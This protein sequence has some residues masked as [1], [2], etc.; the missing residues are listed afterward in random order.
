MTRRTLYTLSLLYLSLPV[1]IFM[2]GWL[3]WP[4]GIPLAVVA[5]CVTATAYRGMTGRVTFGPLWM[6]L[7]MAAVIAVWVVHAG[8]GG[9]VWQ[10]WGDHDFRN[11]VF[12]DLVSYPWPVVRGS[13]MLCYYFGFWLPAA[14]VG[15]LT[16]SLMAGRLMEVVWCA[17]GIWLVVRLVFDL[18]GSVKLRTLWIVLL[19]GGV[20]ILP[21]LLCTGVLGWYTTID[22]EPSL[23]LPQIFSYS[24]IAWWIN[25]TTSL[26]YIYNQMGAA[27][28]GTL[29]VM[30]GSGRHNFQR[31]IPLVLSLMLLSCPFPAVGLLPAGAWLWLKGGCGRLLNVQTLAAVALA[32]PV[33]LLFAG[34]PSV[35]RPELFAVHTPWECVKLVANIVMFVGCQ[36]AVWFPFVWGSIRRDTAFWILFATAVCALTVR[37]GSIGF[38][39]ASRASVPMQLWLCVYVCRRADGWAAMTRPVKGAFLTVAVLCLAEPAAEWV[40][41][42]I[43]MATTPRREWMRHT[44]ATAFEFDVCRDN[45]IAPLSPLSAAATRHGLL[46]HTPGGAFG[47]AE[48]ME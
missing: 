31:N 47:R 34:N 44:Y 10:G 13:E 7:L 42:D 20:S 1:A 32:L 37:V 5:L 33:V 41:T 19:F 16:G 26:Y 11:T 17:W 22:D 3:P 39:F 14:L 12:A 21:F 28:I 36:A 45:F 15:K 27:W 8:I 48:N 46:R 35:N 25:H 40:R 18:L 30:G 38:D 23:L 24:P 43:K 9:F 6:E 29:L 2:L 4:A